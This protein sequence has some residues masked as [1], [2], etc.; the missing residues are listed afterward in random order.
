MTLNEKMQNDNIILQDLFFTDDF[1]LIVFLSSKKHPIYHIKK[2]DNGHATV[3]FKRDI[4]LISDIRF[5]NDKSSENSAKDFAF[6][7][8][9]VKN[10]INETQN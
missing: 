9:I 3:Y 4:Q 5:W 2:E 1:Y 6:Q 10:L 8:K 7:I